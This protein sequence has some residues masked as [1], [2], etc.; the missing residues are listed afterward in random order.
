MLEAL[1]ACGGDTDTVASIAG[2]IAGTALG[3][4]AL[5]AGLVSCLPDRDTII[6][7]VN[8]FTRSVLAS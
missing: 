3:Y 6:E 4:A 5:P 1:I 7:T 8:L 2:Q